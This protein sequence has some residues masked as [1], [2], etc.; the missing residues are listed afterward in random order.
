VE[1]LNLTFEQEPCRNRDSC[2]DAP[3]C[4]SGF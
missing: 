3:G 2:V 4:A 1:L